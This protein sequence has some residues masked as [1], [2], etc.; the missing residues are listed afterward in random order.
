MLWKKELKEGKRKGR[1]RKK[2]KKEI[3]K[4]THYRLLFS[5][6]SI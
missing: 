5:N 6:L 1:I 4:N 3:K 2:E